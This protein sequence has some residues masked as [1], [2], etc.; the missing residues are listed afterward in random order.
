MDISFRSGAFSGMF[1]CCSLP[2]DGCG[3]SRDGADAQSQLRR[4]KRIRD[5]PKLQSPPRHL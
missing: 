5:D 1:R 3:S 4:Q 2:A